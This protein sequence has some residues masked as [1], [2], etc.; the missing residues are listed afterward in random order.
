MR[1][2]IG[3]PAWLRTLAAQIDNKQ[4]QQAERRI[5]AASLQSLIDYHD[6]ELAN[7]QTQLNRYRNR[8]G[9]YATTRNHSHPLPNLPVQIP[10]PRGKPSCRDP[11]PH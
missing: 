10:M 9:G 8:I 7:L 1:N 2:L 5:Y 3:H 11:N 4:R 6:R